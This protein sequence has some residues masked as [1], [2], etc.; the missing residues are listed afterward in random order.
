MVKPIQTFK[1]GPVTAS[2]WVNRQV[3]DNNPVE[4][5]SITIEKTY[6]EKT[7][8]GEDSTKNWKHTHTFT[9]EDLPKVALVAQEAYKFLRLRPQTTSPPESKERIS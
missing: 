9:T 7:T 8:D 5:H 2:L 6:L 1:C 4:F 3:V